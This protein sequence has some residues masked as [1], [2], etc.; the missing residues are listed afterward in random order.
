MAGSTHAHTRTHTLNT[1]I[2]YIVSKECAD[3]TIETLAQMFRDELYQD[4]SW[5]P[6]E[7][8]YETTERHCC[9]S[10]V[11]EVAGSFQTVIPL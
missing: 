5:Q 8:R 7:V 6:E 11:A 10:Y 3:S 9:L 4:V 2:W 1:C